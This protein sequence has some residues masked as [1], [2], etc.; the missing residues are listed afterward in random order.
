VA[1]RASPG[2]AP[3]AE[4]AVGGGD[5]AEIGVMGE[6]AVAAVGAETD[7]GLAAGAAV[8]VETGAGLAAVAAVGAATDAGVVAGAG[9]GGVAVCAAVGFPAGGG[10]CVTAAGFAA[11]LAAP[12]GGDDGG[13][14]AGFDAAVD[15][16]AGAEAAADVE[17]ALCD[18][19]GSGLT[20]AIPPAWRAV[21]AGGA[22]EAAW[23]AASDGRRRMRASRPATVG[24][25]GGLRLRQRRI[26]STNFEGSVSGR[27]TLSDSSGQAGRLCVRASTTVMPSPQTSPAGE[28]VPERASGGS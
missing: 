22:T 12:A 23:G 16:A 11:T 8:G 25:E 13:A 24:R 10:E 7:A 18:A 6:A 17:A 26:M 3:A 5:E 9:D 14:A 4:E 21:A 19:F 2:G 27:E 20:L 28:T 15:A 1:A